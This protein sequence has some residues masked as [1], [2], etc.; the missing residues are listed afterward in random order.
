M[1]VWRLPRSLEISG[2]EFFIRTDFRDILYALKFFSDPEYSDYEKAEICLTVMYPDYDETCSVEQ[3]AEM[4]KKVCEFIDM[5]LTADD[6]SGKKRPRTMDWEKDAKI[7]IPGINKVLGME[8]R[9]LEYM[10]W[11]TFLSAYMEIGE[12]VF[13]SVVNIRTKKSKG[14]K[15]EKWEKEF[16]KENKQ[17]IDLD[18]KKTEEQRFEHERM[19]NVRKTLFV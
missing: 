12:G 8:V 7:I 14:E 11:W 4:L 1:N 3:K 9:A 10:H 18:F 19:M 13:A 6:G 17:L 5:G 15:L 16:A 2:R